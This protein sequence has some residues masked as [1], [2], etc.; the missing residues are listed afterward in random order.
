MNDS[1][2]LS[3][4]DP[5]GKN[6]TAGVVLAHQSFSSSCLHPGTSSPLTKGNFQPQHRFYS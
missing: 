5:E 6:P 4:D 3:S 2:K 1:C